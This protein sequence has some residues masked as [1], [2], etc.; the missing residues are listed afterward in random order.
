MLKKHIIKKIFFTFFIFSFPLFLHSQDL[1]KSVSLNGTALYGLNAA[2]GNNVWHGVIT[3]AGV[4]FDLN[5][6]KTA[7]FSIHT[8]I[9]GDTY[10]L[11]SPTAHAETGE[12]YMSTLQLQSAQLALRLEFPDAFQMKSF[13]SGGGIIYFVNRGG[14]LKGTSP[15]SIVESVGFIGSYAIIFVGHF[16]DGVKFF[17][18]DVGTEI[19]FKHPLV[20]NR[21]EIGF[22]LRLKY[23]V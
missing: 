14:M 10:L 15:S 11:P 22:Y 23:D 9:L 1:I 2:N 13:Y 6:F 4:G 5:V 17:D 18:L 19:Q 8:S 12:T 21:F 20:E 3:G 16:F 7:N